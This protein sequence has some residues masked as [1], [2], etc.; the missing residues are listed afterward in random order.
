MLALICSF[1]HSAHSIR[2]ISSDHVHDDNFLFP[3]DV[4][5][6]LN[7]YVVAMMPIVWLT[8]EIPEGQIKETILG[9]QNGIIV[10]K[11]S[12][13][14]KNFFCLFNEDPVRSL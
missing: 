9:M 8:K 10:I 1:Y 2:L 4:V 3:L 12:I 5:M 14:T 7:C 13:F 6:I 11:L